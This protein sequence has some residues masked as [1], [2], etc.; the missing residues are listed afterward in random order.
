[1]MQS[2]SD[3]GLKE[4]AQKA[5]AM[6]HGDR[7]SASLRIRNIPQPDHRKPQLAQAYGGAGNSVRSDTGNRARPAKKGERRP[8]V[9]SRG[10]KAVKAA[11][12]PSGCQQL[13]PPVRAGRWQKLM[14]LFRQCC[15]SSTAFWKCGLK[16]RVDRV[17]RRSVLQVLGD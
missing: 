16:A 3:F 9:K 15:E 4:T 14:R 6:R 7:F 10:L 5:E 17:Q 2:A 1:M 12:V 8:V 11:V 13:D